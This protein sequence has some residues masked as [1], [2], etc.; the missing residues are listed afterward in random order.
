MESQGS[1]KTMEEGGRRIGEGGVG[2]EARCERKRERQWSHVRN[3]M[4]LNKG[5]EIRVRSW[6][7]EQLER[8][9]GDG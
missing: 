7:E 9:E 8:N 5:D 6:R 1:L 4:F 3:D 2:T